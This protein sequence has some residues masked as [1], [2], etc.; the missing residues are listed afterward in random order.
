[1][2]IQYL[3]DK[4]IRY[5]IYYCNFDIIYDLHE[6]YNIYRRSYQLARI[7]LLIDLNQSITLPQNLKVLK[8]KNWFNQPIDLPGSKIRP[9]LPKGLK[10]LYL[11]F[12][13]NQPLILPKGLRSE[14]NHPIKILPKKLEKLYLSEKYDHPINHLE[15]SNLKIIRC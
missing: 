2:F 14:F 12:N 6:E 1:M 10:K 11:G 15:N 9:G 7:N 5:F 4:Y 8:L 3:S 13:F